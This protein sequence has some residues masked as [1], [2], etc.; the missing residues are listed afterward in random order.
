LGTWAHGGADWRF[1]WGPQDDE[2]SMKT[3]HAALD[4]GVNWIDCAA[5]YGLGHAEEVLGRALKGLRKRPFIAT[6]CSL[7]WNAK[8]EITNCLKKKSVKSEC[9]ASLR[10]LGVEVIDLYQ[11]HWPSPKE[12]IEEGWEAM[13][14]LVREGKVRFAGVSNFNA[15]QMERIRSIHPIAS[16]QPPYS[17][18]RRDVE[19]EILPYCA[20]HRIGVIAYSPLQKGLLTGKVTKDYVA[21]LPPKDHRVKLDP[22]FRDPELSRILSKVE[23]LKSA[24]TRLKVPPA[25]LA[26]TWVLRRPEVTAAIVGARTPEHIRGTAPA[27]DIEL[28]ADVAAELDRIFP[29][30]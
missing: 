13:A 14:E 28:P 25:Q 20:K 2:L 7:V 8:G 5:V 26:I 9:E 27:M 24:A 16:L 17:L 10:R 1:G 22:M 18:L 19:K 30:S 6:K 3:V 4:A 15:A 23:A 11:I 12:Q 29:V 21:S